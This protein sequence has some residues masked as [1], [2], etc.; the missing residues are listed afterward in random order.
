MQ[1]LTA[2]GAFDKNLN[3]S[4]E[5]KLSTVL[6]SERT[7]Q[8]DLFFDVCS[9]LNMQPERKGKIPVI[10]P[11]YSAISMSPDQFKAKQHSENCTNQPTLQTSLLLPLLAGFGKLALRLMPSTF[12]TFILNKHRRIIYWEELKQG[13]I[14]MHFSMVFFLSDVKTFNGR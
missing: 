14:L 13:Y 1:V 10:N 4:S 2:L 5:C 6:Q 7:M 12:K 9:Q 3:S 11:T 8:V